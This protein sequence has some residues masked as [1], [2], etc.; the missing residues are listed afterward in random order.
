MSEWSEAAN[1]RM[2][3]RLRVAAQRVPQTGGVV[4]E[5]LLKRVVGLTLEAVGCQ[6]QIGSRLSE[7]AAAS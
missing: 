2:A 5:G 6:A 7:N 1:V 4:A 3:R